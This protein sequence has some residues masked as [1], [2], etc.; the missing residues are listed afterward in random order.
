MVS[1]VFFLLKKSIHGLGRDTFTCN[2][3][4]FKATYDLTSYLITISSTSPSMAGV[5]NYVLRRESW[6]KCCNDYSYQINAA[7]L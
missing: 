7:A 2:M 1:H 4:L 3:D 6:Y 5:P